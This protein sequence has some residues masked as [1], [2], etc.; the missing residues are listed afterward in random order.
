MSLLRL[1]KVV[2]DYGSFDALKE[3]DFDVY[4]GEVIT[5]FGANGAG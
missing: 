5:L 4:T 3:F 2:V 1:E